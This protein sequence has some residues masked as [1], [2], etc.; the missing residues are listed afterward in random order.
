MTIQEK[1][2][3]LCIQA[4]ILG[5]C[6]IGEQLSK[7]NALMFD[8]EAK[9]K[10]SVFRKLP[11]QTKWDRLEPCFYFRF[12]S[13]GNKQGVIAY[14]WD[15]L[16][17]AGWSSDINKGEVNP[18]PDYFELKVQCEEHEIFYPHVSEILT[19]DEAV[20]ALGWAPA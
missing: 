16:V 4:P 1:I 6:K 9:D 20:R 17:L 19:V 10:E 5:A 3:N 15:L 13:P 2:R 14:I 12:A 8:A 11:G 7:G 18:T